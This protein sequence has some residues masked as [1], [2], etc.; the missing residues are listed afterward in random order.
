[1]IEIEF[2][3]VCNMFRQVTDPSQQSPLEVEEIIHQLVQNVL[4]KILKDN[5]SSDDVRVF[6]YK[7]F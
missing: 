3:S 5:S 2:L 6:R 4:R 1:M 7:G